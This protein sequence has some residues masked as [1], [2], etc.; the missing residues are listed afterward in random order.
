MINGSC[1]QF[2]KHR[3][4]K[5]S[6]S[7]K[8]RMKLA[9]FFGQKL[10]KYK[11]FKISSIS[12][13]FR[14]YCQNCVSIFRQ[15]LQKQRNL[16]FSLSYLSYQVRYKKVLY[17]RAIDF[18]PLEYDFLNFLYFWDSIDSCLQVFQ[19]VQNGWK[20]AVFSH[21][22]VQSFETFVVV[23]LAK[24]FSDKIIHFHFSFT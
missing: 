3:N 18:I 22:E 1:R 11:L 12:F 10:I 5:K 17:S 16:S 23:F 9:A 13:N 19:S 6:C 2:Q 8:I 4:F 15:E 7:K 14:P 21:P 24:L 20:F